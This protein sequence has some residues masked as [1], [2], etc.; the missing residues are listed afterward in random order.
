MV[1]LQVENTLVITELPMRW[2]GPA[3][4]LITL[5]KSVA[6][7]YAKMISIDYVIGMMRC[8]R[9]AEPFARFL[10]PNAGFFFFR[11]FFKFFLLSQLPLLVVAR[12]RSSTWRLDLPLTLRRFLMH[13]VQSVIERHDFRITVFK[14]IR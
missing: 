6:A 4:N 8:F 1:M 9:T 7:V 11:I 10:I 2:A 14:R 5:D 3:A 12:L 13:L